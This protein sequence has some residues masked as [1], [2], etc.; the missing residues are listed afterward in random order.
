MEETRILEQYKTKID[1]EKGVLAQLRAEK[2]M[3]EK[4]LKNEFGLA[5]VE[6]AEKRL[7]RVKRQIESLGKEFTQKLEEVEQE[8]PL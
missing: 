7:I 2:K 4:D 5:T 8:Y 3:I 6:E 1:E